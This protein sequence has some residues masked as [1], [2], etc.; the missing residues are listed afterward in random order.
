MP[1]S[2]RLFVGLGGRSGIPRTSQGGRCEHRRAGY[3]AGKQGARARRYCSRCARRAAV[4]SGSRHCQALRGP[5]PNRNPQSGGGS[6]AAANEV[7]AS[8]T[9]A[10][11][12]Q[13]QG[14]RRGACVPHMA[15]PRAAAASRSCP[16]SLVT[17]CIAALSRLDRGIAAPSMLLLGGSTAS[18]H[19]RQWQQYTRAS[20]LLAG[21][22]P[23]QRA[24]NQ[25]KLL[26][27]DAPDCARAHVVDATNAKPTSTEGRR[28]IIADSA[29][30]L[31]R[32]LAQR[33]QTTATATKGRS[34]NEG[35]R[36]VGYNDR[37][38]RGGTTAGY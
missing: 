1:V 5:G 2:F 28:H 30:A 14:A 34:K 24:G 11:P 3:W 9:W 16:L 18:M 29:R 15:M 7:P 22:R 20:V 33:A 13:R 36:R 38:I 4:S 37:H 27:H 35:A 23:P 26:G 8:Y 32:A 19:V 6:T 12:K 10:G 21:W 31:A 17:N 25:R